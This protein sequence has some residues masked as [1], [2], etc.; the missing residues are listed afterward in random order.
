MCGRG[1]WDPPKTVTIIVAAC[2][3]VPSCKTISRVEQHEAFPR[4]R[5]A[6]S[7]KTHP[8]GHCH[9]RR[10]ITARS[11]A[12]RR[13]FFLGGAFRVGERWLSPL[14]GSHDRLSAMLLDV[15]V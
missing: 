15:S 2:L 9:Y 4:L 6:K 7:L 11:H 10:L 5:L 3:S 14:Q 8:Y 13:F 12:E 1:R